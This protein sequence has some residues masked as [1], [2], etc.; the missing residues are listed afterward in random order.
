MSCIGTSVQE[1]VAGQECNYA[2]LITRIWSKT[3]RWENLELQR[4]LN[5]GGVVVQYFSF[6]DRVKSET[7]K[8]VELDED[9]VH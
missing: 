6:S 2:R 7:E 4:G 1:R 3:L 9:I 8:T 5:Y